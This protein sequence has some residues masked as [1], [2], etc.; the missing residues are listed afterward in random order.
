MRI[1][2][3]SKLNNFLN[4]ISASPYN[5]AALQVG[6]FQSLRSTE[7]CSVLQSSSIHSFFRAANELICF[8]HG[9]E[10]GSVIEF[11]GGRYANSYSSSG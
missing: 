7:M 8:A 2:G 1:L 11:R 4:M 3:I 10:V 6:R 5:I 9:I